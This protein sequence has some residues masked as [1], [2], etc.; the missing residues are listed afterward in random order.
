[1]KYF[2]RKKAVIERIIFH[3]SSQLKNKIFFI[4]PY[5]QSYYFSNILAQ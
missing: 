2:F 3:I 1:M 5:H 4:S